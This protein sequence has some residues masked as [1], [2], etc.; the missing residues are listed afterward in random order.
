[1]KTKFLVS[2]L[3]VGLGLLGCH[4]NAITGR[5]QLS[6][7]SESEVQ[8]I[9]KQST[10]L[11]LPKIKLLELLP[12]KMQQWLQELENVLLLQLLNITLSKV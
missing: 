7:I 10:K 9:P 2:S 4:R 1:M 8:T 3:V 12:V 11:F 6:L 5:N